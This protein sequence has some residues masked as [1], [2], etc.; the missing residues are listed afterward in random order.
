MN[1][2]VSKVDANGDGISCLAFQLW[3]KAGCP[4]GRDLEFWLRAEACPAESDLMPD[5][6]KASEVAELDSATS[7]GE[8]QVRA[9]TLTPIVETALPFKTLFH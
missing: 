2:N 1:Q 6:A 4:E 3:E 8:I 9:S 5:A 7:V